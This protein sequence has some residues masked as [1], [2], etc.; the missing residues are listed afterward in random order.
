MRAVGGSL[1]ALALSACA[2][3]ES[4]REPAHRTPE[5]LVVMAPAIAEMLDVLGEA[6]RV[7]GVGDFVTGTAAAGRPR[8]GAYDAPSVERI[9]ELRA[10]LYLTSASQAALPVHREL[11][12]LGVRVLALDTSTYDGVFVALEALGRI[13]AREERAGELARDMRARLD[14]IGRTAEGL[15]RRRVLCLVGRDPIFVAGP[16]SHLDRLIALAGGINVFADVAAPYERVSLE[17]ALERMPEVIIDIAEGDPTAPR[18]KLAGAWAGFGFLPAVREERVFSVDP[19][20]LA[21]PGIRLPEMAT[22]V[23]RMVHPEA[24]GEPT[25]AELGAEPGAPG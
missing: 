23:S 22:L 24:F 14:A 12:S 1:L 19:S 9:V 6:R 18:G 4:T 3:G 16:G 11:E 7:V 17:L 25:A 13:L 5:R 8:L 21:V 15:P 10:D 20:L 2:P